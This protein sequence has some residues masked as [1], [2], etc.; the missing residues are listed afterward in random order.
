MMP[1][2]YLARVHRSYIVALSSITSVSGTNDI[3]IGDN[4]IHVSDA[5]RERFENYLKGNSLN[6]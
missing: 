6:R 5:Y 3:L 2:P 4:L 1:S